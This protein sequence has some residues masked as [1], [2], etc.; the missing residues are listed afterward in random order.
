[1]AEVC[2]LL[3]AVALD[4]QYI[5]CM[6]VCIPCCCCCCW[7]NS[8]EEVECACERP[9]CPVA[10][11]FQYRTVPRPRRSDVCHQQLLSVFI[12]MMTMM[13]LMMLMMIGRDWKPCDNLGQ[14][15]VM[16]CNFSSVI[17]LS[18]FHIRALHHIM[19]FLI[20]SGYYIWHPM[21]PN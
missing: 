12:I 11:F 9:A 13:T 1:M 2:T 14:S 21:L 15:L 7:S 19:P 17:R 3:D 16:D 4:F 10:R 5:S 8:T 6:Y 18:S 20:V